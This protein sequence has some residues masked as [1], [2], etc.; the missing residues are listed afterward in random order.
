M[1]R[2]HVAF[3]DIIL[4]G[5]EGIE[6]RI[7]DNPAKAKFFCIHVV[8]HRFF[9][10]YEDPTWKPS[11]LSKSFVEETPCIIF[12]TSCERK[13]YR[14]F[15]RYRANWMEKHYTCY[16]WLMYSP[17]TPRKHCSKEELTAFLNEIPHKE[18]VCIE[19][20]P[21]WEFGRAIGNDS[22]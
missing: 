17:F 16:G 18:E 6:K 14:F 12:Y 7:T 2:K 5:E 22:F 15:P 4:R 20:H 21:L 3:K 1:C 13:N 8:N 11:E 9:V 10:V 19:D